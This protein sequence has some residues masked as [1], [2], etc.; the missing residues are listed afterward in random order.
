[1]AR[2]PSKVDVTTATMR[3]VDLFAG[4]GGMSLGFQKAGFQIVAAFDHWLP[5]VEVYEK[6]FSHSVKQ[7][8]LG[9][10]AMVSEIASLAPD[11][12]I[13]G[14]P[15]QDFSSAGLGK[16]NG[17]RANL[18][19]AYAK[20]I[21]ATKPKYF[22]FENVP[23]ARLSKVFHKAKQEFK[24][25]GYGLTEVELDAAYCGVPQTR[26]RIFLIGGFEDSDNF[27]EHQLL[28]NLAK[29]PMSM[30][31]Y[32]GKGLGIDYYFR[33]PTNYSRRGIFSVD[34]PCMTIRAVDRPLP[35]GYIGHKDDPVPVSS[36]VRGLT[37]EERGRVQTFP[38]SFKFFGT[39]TDMNTLIG[40]AV[41]VN[42]ANYVATNLMKYINSAD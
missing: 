1:M 31:S 18:T 12:I 26:K 23:R 3:T 4:C 7:A 19:G 33:V 17:D 42:L 13:G 15:C 2:Y 39:K 24:K 38:K 27:L 25:H 40:N 6:N 30:R 35:K 28:A 20:I 9:D 34:E 14:P 22:V 21:T 16:L 37:V 5:A 29:K 41:P 36:G 10:P 11:V 8:D 32:F